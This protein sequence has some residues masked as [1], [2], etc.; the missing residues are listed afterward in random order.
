MLHPGL[1][2]D[3]KSMLRTFQSFQYSC[4]FCLHWIQRHGKGMEGAHLP[5][6]LGGKTQCFHAFSISGFKPLLK[7]VPLVRGDQ[8]LLLPVQPVFL[9]MEDFETGLHLYTC[10]KFVWPKTRV[11]KTPKATRQLQVPMASVVV[12]RAVH[13]SWNLHDV[14]GNYLPKKHLRKYMLFHQRWNIAALSISTGW[15]L[16]QARSGVDAWT[17]L[18]WGSLTN[19]LHLGRVQEGQLRDNPKFN[20]TWDIQKTVGAFLWWDILDKLLDESWRYFVYPNW[21][22]KQSRRTQL[23]CLLP[24]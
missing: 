4:T 12:G 16:W 23:Q 8:Q 19:S 9:P 2:K 20:E 5:K 14:Q 21:T 24:S 11:H 6:V 7:L 22:G 18:S 17:T 3:A 13:N 15:W 10:W 1:R